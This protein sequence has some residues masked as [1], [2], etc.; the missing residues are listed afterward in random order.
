MARPLRVEFSGAV[1]H[2]TARGNR[3]EAIY[4]D[5][6]DRERHLALMAHAMERFEAKVLA[7]CQMGNHYHLVVQ[8]LQPNLSRLMRHLNG[9]Y[10]QTFN[11]RHGKTGHL[12]EGRF[13]AILVDRDSYLLALCRYV[14]RNPVA[15]GL[16]PSA[17]DWVWSSYRAHAGMV[18]SPPWLEVDDIHALLRGA[19]VDTPRAR[20]RAVAAYAGWVGQARL[21]DSTFWTDGLRG[22]VFLGD[23]KFVERMQ[24]QAQPARLGAPGI[25]RQQRVQAGDWQHYLAQCQ[26]QRDL[27]LLQAY[28]GGLTMT[29]LATASGLS[30]SHVSRLIARG[31]SAL[32]PEPGKEKRET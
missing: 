26:N 28:R 8:T 29:A 22:Q 30:I 2:V 20:Q 24:A 14:E 10:T 9:S 18:A 23:A 12:F 1:Y 16:V 32:Q 3:K 25:P 7:Y 5:D 21:D 17:G 15:A 13:K 27:A 11:R 6:L 19:P 4:A 31:E